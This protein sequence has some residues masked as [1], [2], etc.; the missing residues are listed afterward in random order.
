[1]DPWRAR[2]PDVP[3]VNVKDDKAAG[4]PQLHCQ[5]KRHNGP[6]APRHPDVPSVNVKDDKA[7]GAPLLH[8]QKSQWTR[9]ALATPTSPV[10]T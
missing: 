10:S 2:P 1:M 5:I 9:G 7:A 8:C 4:A 6:V 3:S